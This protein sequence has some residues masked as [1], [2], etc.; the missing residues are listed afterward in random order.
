[1]ASSTEIPTFPLKLS[2]Q[3]R[4]DQKERTKAFEKELRAL[5]KGTG[6]RSAQGTLFRAQGDWFVSNLPTLAFQRGVVVRWTHKPMK[7]DPLFWSIFGLDENNKMP[8]SF[9]DQGAWTI[10]PATQQFYLSEDVT[11]P[12]KLAEDTLAYSN[13]RLAEVEMLT[14][15]NLLSEY[16]PFSSNKGMRRTIAVCLLLLVG[17]EN[18]A[19]ELCGDGNDSGSVFDRDSGGFAHD[20]ITFFDAARQ[21]IIANRVAT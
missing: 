4:K 2:R 20:N 15:E 5:A 12:L 13:E 10:R 1:M 16:E 21:W 3:E 19:L 9:R 14:I 6:W 11:D 7:I 17:R 8:L 18:E